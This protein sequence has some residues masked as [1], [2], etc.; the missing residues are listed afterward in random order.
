M[1][2]KFRKSL[3]LLICFVLGQTGRNEYDNNQT[4]EQPHVISLHHHQK[5][6]TQYSA[7]P[8]I[9]PENRI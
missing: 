4:G 3:C 9:I 1:Y 2:Y 7:L 5:R 8:Q 6:R